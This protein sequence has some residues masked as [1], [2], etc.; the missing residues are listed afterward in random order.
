MGE[1]LIDEA[2]RAEIRSALEDV[3]ETF[4]REIKIFKRKAE[5]FV[6]TTSTYNALYSRLKKN[7]KKPLYKVEEFTA[8]ARIDYVD[9][10]EKSALGG[11]NAQVN[12]PLPEG[13]IR[14]KID[15][16]GFSHLKTASSVEIDGDLYELISDSAKTGPFQVHYFV[17]YL[18][19]K[20]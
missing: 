14:L 3:H 10:Q 19:R 16:T 18:K 8:K 1:D 12:V 15:E 13:M 20:D 6:S 2:M 4:A 7:Q 5:V 9:K 11:L 17:M